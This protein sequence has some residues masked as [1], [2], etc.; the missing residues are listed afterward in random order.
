MTEIFLDNQEKKAAFSKFIKAEIDGKHIN[1]V[2]IKEKLDIKNDSNLGIYRIYFKNEWKRM[3]KT[4]DANTLKLLV[5]I[6]QFKDV[7]DL[8]DAWGKYYADYISQNQ[9]R[10]SETAKL[11]DE[12]VDNAG[13]AEPIEDDKAFLDRIRAAIINPSLTSH[14]QI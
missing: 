10:Y 13:F 14:L 2:D 6:L 9:T 4:P 5:E 7:R 1:D 12:N 11:F 3:G 8:E